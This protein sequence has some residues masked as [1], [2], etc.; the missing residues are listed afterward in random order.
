MSD[1]DCTPGREPRI[2]AA[3]LYYYL[4][5]AKAWF[6]YIATSFPIFLTRIWNQSTGKRTN[7]WHFK[8]LIFSKEMEINI[9]DIL[10]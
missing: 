6:F 8:N 4:S 3:S 9:L 2:V 7:G 1:A 10:V 5:C